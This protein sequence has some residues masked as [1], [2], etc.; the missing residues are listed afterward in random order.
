M[1]RL[2]LIRH[3][4]THQAKIEE[5]DFDRMLTERGFKDAAL[6]GER[7]KKA[8]IIPEIILSSTAKRAEQTANIIAGASYYSIENISWHPDFYQCM[9]QAFLEALYSLDDTMETAFIIAHNP[10]ISMFATE[11]AGAAMQIEMPTCGIVGIDLHT[12]K[13]TGLHTAKKQLFLVDTPKKQ[14]D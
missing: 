3:A 13:W 2:I 10:G 11:L 4:K 12:A 7:L 14:H 5:R 6:M 1:K 9:P 8:G